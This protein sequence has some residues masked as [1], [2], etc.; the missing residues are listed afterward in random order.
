VVRAMPQFYIQYLLR[1]VK[2]DL[3]HID[4]VD[5]DWG[6]LALDRDQWP[7]LVNVVM[8]FRVPYLVRNFFSICVTINF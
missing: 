2:T 6:H 8:N 1:N 3:Q 5:V 7:T 4:C